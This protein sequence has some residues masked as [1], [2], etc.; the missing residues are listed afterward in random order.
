ME[1]LLT[2]Q[3]VAERWGCHPQSIYRN[4]E[5]PFVHVPG[6]GKRYKPSELEEYLTSKKEYKKVKEE[7]K[8]QFTHLAVRELPRSGKPQELL[9][10]YGISAAHIEAAVKDIV[11]HKS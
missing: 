10:K 1:K 7:Y 2:A 4:K 8:A 6:I 9:D 5:L 11:R 3:E